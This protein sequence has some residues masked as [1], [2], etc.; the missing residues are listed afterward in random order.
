MAALLLGS[1]VL[2]AGATSAKAAG[3]YLQEQS[4]S[5][6]GA[7][8]AGQA[9]I[10]RDASIMYFNPAGMARLDGAQLNA[11][12]H[13]IAPQLDMVDNGTALNAGFT[14]VGAGVGNDDGGNPAS[15]G[16]IP[17]FY[18][19]A[20]IA[21]DGNLWAGIGV[22]A[23]FGFGSQFDSNFF[24]RFDS[25]KSNLKTIDV[26]PTLAYNINDHVSVGGG[27]I[28]QYADASLT[29]STAVNA[30]GGNI[31]ERDQRLAGDDVSLGYNLGVT[32]DVTPDTTLGFAYR[33]ETNHV[34]DGKITLTGVF[35]APGKAALDLPA[36]ASAAITHDISERLTGLFQLTWFGWESF[37]TIHPERDDGTAV[38]EVRQEYDNTW[39]F[40]VGA[41]YKLNDQWTIRGGYQ[42]DQ[43]PTNDQFRT[44]RTPDGDRHWFAAGATYEINDRWSFDFSTTYINVEEET[45]NVQRGAGSDIVNVRAS[46]DDAYVLIG[47]A[48]INFKF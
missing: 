27:L 40:A 23:P 32:F 24:A 26:Q 17:N 37:A 28:V 35:D 1:A 30:G 4:V 38:P 6:L 29:S 11:G 46:T 36:I 42:F 5:G 34:L 19:A 10:S 18:M 45:I 12:V 15:P 31:I 25:V 7:A 14:F 33:S 3:F 44:T 16:F 22:S 2:I 9:A 48:A 20:P 8:F 41:D 39:A 21:F 13:V 47:A 43:T